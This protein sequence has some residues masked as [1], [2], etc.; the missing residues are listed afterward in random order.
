M[1]EPAQLK[2]SVMVDEARAHMY[3]FQC[4]GCLGKAIVVQGR[5]ARVRVQHNP[6]GCPIKED[7]QHR[8][9]ML[10]ARD[11]GYRASVPEVQFE[12][13]EIVELP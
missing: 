2:G 10:Y 3:G 5:Q 13:A 9:P 7:M 6:R 11:M 4:A 12:K 1:P 8:H